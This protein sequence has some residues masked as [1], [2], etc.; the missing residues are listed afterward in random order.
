[1]RTCPHCL[2]FLNAKKA[3]GENG[4]KQ[5]KANGASCKKVSIYPAL[6]GWCHG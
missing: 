3:G 4:G 2:R 5:G 1:M 6:F